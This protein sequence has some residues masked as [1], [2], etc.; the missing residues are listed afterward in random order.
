MG[1]LAQIGES[2]WKLNKMTGGSVREAGNL[3]CHL[4]PNRNRPTR[5]AKAIIKREEQQLE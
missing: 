3:Y 2:L 1:D 4:V 5:L